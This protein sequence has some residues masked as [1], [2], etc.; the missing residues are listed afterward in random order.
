MR[1]AGRGKRSWWTGHTAMWGQS[2]GKHGFLTRARRAAVAMKTHRS[3]GLLAE[4]PEWQ[5]RIRCRASAFV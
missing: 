4:A 3:C 2:G 5:L 1:A